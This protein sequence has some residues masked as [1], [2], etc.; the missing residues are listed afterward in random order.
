MKV[1]DIWEFNRGK[2]TKYLGNVLID[3]YV[4]GKLVVLEVAGSSVFGCLL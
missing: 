1:N 4:Q 3:F 2:Q